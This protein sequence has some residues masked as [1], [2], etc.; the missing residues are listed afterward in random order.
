M[1]HEHKFLSC[2]KCGYSE[3]NAGCIVK[4]FII[5]G[6]MVKSFVTDNEDD[7]KFIDLCDDCLIRY[8]LEYPNVKIY[9]R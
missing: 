4:S 7:D 6:C 3:E 8:K 9:E 5:A 1:K 2:D